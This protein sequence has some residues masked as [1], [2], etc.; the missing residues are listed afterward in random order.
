M[1]CTRSLFLRFVL[2]KR[3]QQGQNI[4]QEKF[5]NWWITLVKDV[6]CGMDVKESTQFRSEQEEEGFYFCSAQCKKT[7]TQILPSMLMLERDLMKTKP[8][9][10]RQNL[11]SIR[12]D[13]RNSPYTY[14]TLSGQ[15]GRTNLREAEIMSRRSENI[16]LRSE[17]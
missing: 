14:K 5:L 16:H 9:R 3:K 13:S 8:E 11:I 4:N 15:L 7:L 6:V 2:Y 17:Y 10:S 12:K 1:S